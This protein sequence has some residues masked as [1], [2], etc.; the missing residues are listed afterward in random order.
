MAPLIASLLGGLITVVGTMAGRVL[1]ALGVS[2]VTYTGLSSSLDWLKGQMM[3]SLLSLPPEVVGLLSVLKIGVALN[4]YM[5]AIAARLVIGG[6][7]GDTLKR[8]VLK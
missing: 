6:L 4:I 2:V 8:W 3:G 1:V 7:T 5:S